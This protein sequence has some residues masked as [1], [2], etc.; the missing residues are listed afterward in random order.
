MLEL[1]AG[2]SSTASCAS[3]SD[4]VSESPREGLHV[5]NRQTMNS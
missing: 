4:V 3:G 2:D 1:S 5:N